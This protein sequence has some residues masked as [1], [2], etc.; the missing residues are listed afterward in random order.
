MLHGLH[1]NVKEKP[2]NGVNQ[3]NGQLTEPDANVTD[4]NK[5][6][7]FDCFVSFVRLLTLYHFQLLISSLR[8]LS[9]LLVFVIFA[10]SYFFLSFMLTLLFSSFLSP[11]FFLPCHLLRYNCFFASISSFCIFV[12][13]VKLVIFVKFVG[14]MFI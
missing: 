14:P 8:C 2:F 11:S 9:F 10:F 4:V 12:I 13:F 1:C 6:M 3:E 7:R 5:I